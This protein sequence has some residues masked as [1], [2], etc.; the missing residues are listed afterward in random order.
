M[1]YLYHRVPKDMRGN[2]L[3]PLN[4]L[5]TIEPEIY[6]S[7]VKKYKDREWVS[8]Q[9]ITPLSCLWSDVIHLTSVHPSGIIQALREA[10]K[11]IDGEFFEID[12][13]LL[14]PSDT[15]I[16][17]YNKPKDQPKEFVAYD[18]DNLEKYS[19]FSQ[20]V[21][22]YYF[23]MLKNNQEPLLFHLIP[24][25]LYKGAIPIDNAKVVRI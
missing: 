8:E 21:K 1:N 11:D 24:H 14:E 25:I 18:P 20:D 4:K 17:L 5:K 19:K 15:T 16:Y 12:P 9:E 13:Y 3:Y 23:K 2:I 10:G 6:I 22:D 7:A